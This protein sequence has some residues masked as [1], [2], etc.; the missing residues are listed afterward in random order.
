M[1]AE[2]EGYTGYAGEK[3]LGM[4]GTFLPWADLGLLTC[5]SPLVCQKALIASLPL[6][7]SHN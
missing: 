1:L 4:S 6:L 3:G 2:E 7:V 5:R